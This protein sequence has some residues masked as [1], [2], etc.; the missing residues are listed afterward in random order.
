MS[1]KALPAKR[2]YFDT[3][4]AAEHMSVSVDTIRA[5]I[6]TGRLR[7]KYS[8]GTDPETGKRRPGGKTLITAEALDAWFEEMEDA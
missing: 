1:T 2:R 4:Q 6:N 8:A 3:R 7:A 5:A